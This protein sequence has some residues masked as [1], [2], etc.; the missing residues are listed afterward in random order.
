MRHFPSTRNRFIGVF[1]ADKIPQQL[2]FYPC[3]FIANTDPSFMQ[4]THWTAVFVDRNG[5]IEYFDS[6][7]RQP[8]SPQMKHF[9]GLGYRY[10]PY[11][12]QSAYSALCGH[13]CIFYLVYRC[14]GISQENVLNMFN[15]NN[16]T[17][18]ECKVQNFVKFN[19]N[20]HAKNSRL[21]LK[22]RCR[23]YK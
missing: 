17:Y 6:Y 2:Y 14:R 8:L 9:C 18:N 3:C 19:P 7:G 15:L 11:M 13:F 20:V 12:I 21:F 23:P 16:L 1:A 10:N 4:G 22:Q 5:N